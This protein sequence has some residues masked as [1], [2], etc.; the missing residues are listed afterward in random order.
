MSNRY[1]TDGLYVYPATDKSENIINALESIECAIAF[2]VK[3]WEQ[4]DKRCAWIHAIIMGIDEDEDDDGWH[5]S[6]TMK[7]YGWD[8]TDKKRA[9]EYHKQ[10]ERAKKLLGATL[11]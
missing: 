4:T 8:E 11:Q 9:I 6:D 3:C 10:W 5:F 2:D 7:K 1:N